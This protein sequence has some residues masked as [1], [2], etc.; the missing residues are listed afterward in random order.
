[1]SEYDQEKRCKRLLYA[2]TVFLA[3]GLGFSYK[4]TRLKPSDLSLKNV[5]FGMK[6]LG[7]STLICIGIFGLSIVTV[8]R[9]L[10]V[11]NI[12]EFSSVMRNY[13]KTSFPSLKVRS[14]QAD[15]DDTD[16]HVTLKDLSW[17]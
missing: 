11:K 9:A 17:D 7:I 14:N 12:E 2:S 1:M 3:L 16:K 13:M 6:A 15:H 4:Y 8:S 10:K 5:L